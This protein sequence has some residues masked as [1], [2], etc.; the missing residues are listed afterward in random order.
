MLVVLS[1]NSIE[2]DWVEAE[3]KRVRKREKDLKTNI[4]CPV[5]LDDSWKSKL[6]IE[7]SNR[8]LWRTL[9][10]KLIIDFSKWKTKAFETP[11]EKLMRGLKKN[12]P[13]SATE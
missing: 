4:L 11:F 12:Y 13:P 10:D 7:S 9:T 6:D 3:I 2:S 8:A 5:A 1:E